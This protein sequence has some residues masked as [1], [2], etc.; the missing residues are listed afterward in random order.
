MVNL[1]FTE[2]EKKMFDGAINSGWQH[3]FTNAEEDVNMEV[4]EW[5]SRGRP[6]V[7]SVVA[8][9]GNFTAVLDTG[10]GRMFL[11]DTN[12]NEIAQTRQHVAILNNVV[13]L[14]K[15]Y[16]GTKHW[17]FIADEAEEYAVKL[18]NLF[19]LIQDKKLTEAEQLL[20]ELGSKLSP[21]CTELNKARLMLKKEQHRATLHA[22]NDG[23]SA[24]LATD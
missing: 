6:H 21:N 7:L 3:C 9:I 13:F 4:N 2:Q 22:D 11:L 19:D 1:G 14:D 8:R 18:G 5:V 16:Y 20:D 24:G 12:T 23:N 10:Y 15:E 17:L